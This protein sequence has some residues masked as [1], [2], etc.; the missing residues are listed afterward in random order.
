MT[1]QR[2]DPEILV[3]VPSHISL[4]ALH[5]RPQRSYHLLIDDDLRDRRNICAER[6]EQ[7]SSL[8]KPLQDLALQRGLAGCWP[9]LGWKR[10]PP[11]RAGSLQSTLPLLGTKS[12]KLLRKLRLHALC[13]P[14]TRSDLA[15]HIQPWR[16]AVAPMRPSCYGAPPANH[17]IGVALILDVFLRDRTGGA[18]H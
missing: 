13:G 7:R 1:L 9:C 12:C 10:I 15:H 5:G 3:L 16:D 2:V 14:G 11:F 18:C 17:A 4:R 6:E 8:G